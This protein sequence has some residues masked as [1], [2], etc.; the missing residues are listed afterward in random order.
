MFLFAIATVIIVGYAYSRTADFARGPRITVATPENGATV[1]SPLASV[2]GIAENSIALTLNGRTLLA[3]EEGAFR[4]EVLLA[5]GYNILTLSAKDR[6]GRMTE[7][8][9][10]VV[11]K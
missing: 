7:E 5:R 2:T 11:R 10:E 1:M 9:I 4:T 8:K 6:F 3:D